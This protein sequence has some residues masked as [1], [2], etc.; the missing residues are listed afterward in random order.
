MATDPYFGTGGVGPS[1]TGPAS[2]T[3]G[4]GG[5]FARWIALII[6]G[7]LVNALGGA[8]ASQL[9]SARSARLVGPFTLTSGTVVFLIGVAYAAAMIS[10]HYQATLGKM[11]MGLKVTDAQGKRLTPGPAVIRELSK[12]LSGLLLGI[13][14]IIAAFN[15]RSQA[16]HDMIAGTIVVR[17]R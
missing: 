13:G 14:Y 5:F 4:Y 9:E 10:S 16:L 1:K 11:V 3:L 8:I 17:S 2:P 12:F 7:F 15:D 6:D